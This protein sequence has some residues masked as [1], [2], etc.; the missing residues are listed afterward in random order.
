MLT[1]ITR[2]AGY[3]IVACRAGGAPTSLA[4]Q[5]LAVAAPPLPR[6]ATASRFFVINVAAVALA[7]SSFGCEA[8][9]DAN[10]PQKSSPPPRTIERLLQFR[11]A[12]D[13]EI[14][15]AWSRLRKAKRDERELIRKELARLYEAGEFRA[16]AAFVL[17]ANEVTAGN[18]EPSVEPVLAKREPLW[19]CRPAEQIDSTAELA[20]MDRFMTEANYSAARETG[21]RAMQQK[22]PACA[23]LMETAVATLAMAA[24]NQP[25]APQ[26]FELSLRTFL[27][28][29]VEMN[30]RPQQGGRSWPFGL[31][32]RA[33]VNYDP[34][35]ALVAVEASRAICAAEQCSEAAIR[36]IDDQEKY[37]RSLFK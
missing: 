20:E 9:R 21:L 23:L 4:K 11:R 19:A 32:A 16:M 26:D 12:S 1:L 31:A 37:I 24:T 35:M 14:G 29:D 3:V 34:P 36:Q 2:L 27:T 25:V 10:L 30:L 8:S 33:L 15:D 18:A 13:P 7:L 17:A 28:A 22:G 6:P 5:T